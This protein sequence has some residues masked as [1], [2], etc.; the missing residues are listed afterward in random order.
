VALV[1]CDG[2]AGAS[3][4][5]SERRGESAPTYSL[6]NDGRDVLPMSRHG[7]QP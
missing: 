3:G 2:A 1:N 7:F 4:I 5:R 6:R